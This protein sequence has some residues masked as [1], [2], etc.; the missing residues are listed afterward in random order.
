[1]A[2]S[3]GLAFEAKG[4]SKVYKLYAPTQSLTS[5]I[6]TPFKALRGG[7]DSA[8]QP[9][10]EVRALDDVSFSVQKG[11]ALG[12][13]GPN[14]A[15]KSTLLKILAR[16]TPPTTGE[17]RGTGRVVPLLEVGSA[18]NR[19]LSARENIHLSAALFKIPDREVR[20][21]FDEI[22]GFAELEKFVDVP[23]FRYS[24]GMY[25]RL[26]FSVAI[27]M[28]PDILLADEILA[29]G[30][31]GFRTRCIERIGELSRSGTTLLFVSHDMEAVVELTD[32]AILLS[33]GRIVEDGEPDDIISSY[34]RQSY[35]LN[36]GRN[37]SGKQGLSQN[38]F[39][40][41]R[42]CSLK[43]VGG[44]TKG[45]VTVNEEFFIKLDF[46][47]REENLE[48][49][50]AIDIYHHG[51]LAFG[52]RNM[53]DRIAEPGFYTCWFRVPKRILCDSVYTVNASIACRGTGMW[54]RAKFQN[55]LTFTA[56]DPE[57]R[58]FA[59]REVGL[60]TPKQWVLDPAMQ[61]EI[62]KSDPLDVV[63]TGE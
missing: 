7:K 28:R 38:E 21:H 61:S 18:F 44:D 45:A 30:D 20:Q 12:I 31:I 1:M 54:K 56:F 5:I 33:Q 11:E 8:S 51:I 52:A 13:I 10:R 34:E 46:E 32:R 49:A 59:L 48:V 42:E 57:D 39:V 9:V 63:N 62:V 58:Y 2:D 17:V 27:N 24:S 60:P 55:A 35:A 47:I 4:V 25:M 3:Q 26:A 50:P 15:G 36:S 29:V 53:P 19:D 41:I 22:I 16:V 37:T 6:K 40:H 43:S 14:G 23:L